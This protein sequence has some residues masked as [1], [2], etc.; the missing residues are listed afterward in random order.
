M[1]DNY[2]KLLIM[3]REVCSQDN[4]CTHEPIFMV[5]RH[6]RTYGFDPSYSEDH[7]VYLQHDSDYCEVD[8]SLA[9]T[10]PKCKHVM[11]KVEAE[12]LVDCPK[13][14]AKLSAAELKKVNR[15]YED[16]Q[17]CPTCENTPSN[18]DLDDESC[19]VCEENPDCPKYSH[20]SLI[21]DLGLTRTAYQG[22]WENVQ[23]FFTRKGAE[24][25]LRINGHN[26]RGRE[27]PRIYVDSPN[28][29][30]EWQA[31]RRMLLGLNATNVMLDEIKKAEAK[32]GEEV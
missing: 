7:V 22:T 16:S 23:P 10:C 31:I 6:K 12:Q 26:L 18:G 4:A 15:D 3:A 2:E 28:R 27:E 19:H 8:T 25:Y 24:E 14:K 20:F 1:T 13:C 5:Q 9:P 21:D 17:K 11:T 30:A 29:N 32:K